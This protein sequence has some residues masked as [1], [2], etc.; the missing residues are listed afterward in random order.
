MLLGIWETSDLNHEKGFIVGIS[1]AFDGKTGYYI[2]INHYQDISLG[3][4]SYRDV[5]QVLTDKENDILV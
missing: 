3:G 2:P 1:F 5:L 4:H